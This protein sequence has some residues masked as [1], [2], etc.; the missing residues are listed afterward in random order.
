[1]ISPEILSYREKFDVQIR[2]G[3]ARMKF[4]INSCPLR[5]HPAHGAQPF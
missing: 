3:L 1:M 2:Q 5:R 4:L